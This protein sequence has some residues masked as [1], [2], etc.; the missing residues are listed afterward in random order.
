[1]QVLFLKLFQANSRI[2]QQEPLH[3]PEAP[4]DHPSLGCSLRSWHSRRLG[5]DLGM[6]MDGE[7]GWFGSKILNKTHQQT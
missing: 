5:E 3:G 1:M 4:E 6:A 7:D 2:A